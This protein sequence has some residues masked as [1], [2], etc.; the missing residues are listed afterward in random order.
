[1][2]KLCGMMINI[3][4]ADSGI[5]GKIDGNENTGKTLLSL[6][7]I[8]IEQINSRGGYELLMKDASGP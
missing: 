4:I 2:Y 3:H 6:A 8:Q 5:A 7:S 1:M